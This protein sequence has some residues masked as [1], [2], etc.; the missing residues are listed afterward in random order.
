MVEKDETVDLADPQG[1]SSGQDRSSLSV[2]QLVN[3]TD[4]KPALHPLIRYQQL[5][6]N[7]LTPRSTSHA[8]CIVRQEIT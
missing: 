5:T 4:T 8:K 2:K 6:S 1:F 7:D 3:L